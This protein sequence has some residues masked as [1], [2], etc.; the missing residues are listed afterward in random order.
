[1]LW[2]APNQPRRVVKVIYRD[3]V[4]LI[5]PRRPKVEVDQPRVEYILVPE[6]LD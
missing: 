4:T 6:K 3:R 2:Q 1:M 5:D